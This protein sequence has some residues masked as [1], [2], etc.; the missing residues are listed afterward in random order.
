MECHSYILLE[1]FREPLRTRSLKKC[2]KTKC[3]IFTSY[4]QTK[5]DSKGGQIKGFDVTFQMHIV[6]KIF[7]IIKYLKNKKN[8]K[9]KKKKRQNRENSPKRPKKAQKGKKDKIFFSDD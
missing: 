4:K 6:A 3:H 9:L 8:Q 2:K 1:G 5:L 7:D